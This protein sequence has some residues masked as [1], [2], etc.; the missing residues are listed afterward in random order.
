MLDATVDLDLIGDYAYE[1]VTLGFS[2]KRRPPSQITHQLSEV[3]ARIRT[4]LTTAI[5]S[6]PSGDRDQAL[7]LL[8]QEAVIRAECGMLYEKLSQLVSWRSCD[9]DFLCGA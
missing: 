7:S 2:L 5:E 6:W 1:I 3:G 8:P 4:S 9:L